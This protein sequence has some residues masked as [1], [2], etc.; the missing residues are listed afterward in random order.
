[1]NHSWG[2]RV[3]S[4]QEGY[5]QDSVAVFAVYHGDKE[6]KKA[7]DPD[8]AQVEVPPPVKLRAVEAVVEWS[9]DSS[10]DHN[11]DTSKV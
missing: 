10:S 8:L 5:G 9:C 11:S 6:S 2:A 1:M 3:P 4:D 7:H